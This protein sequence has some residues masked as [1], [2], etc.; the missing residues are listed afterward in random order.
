MSEEPLRA[1][2]DQIANQL[3]LAVDGKFDFTVKI[4]VAD[5]SAEKLQMLINFVIDTARRALSEL[6]AQKEVA[7]A[8][9]HARSEFL[10]TMSHE[11]RT[12]INGVIGMTG[13]LLDTSL[14]PEQW[15][16]AQA[17]RT[18]GDV[19]LAVINDILDFS[20]IEAGRLTIEPIPFDLQVTV[21]DVAEVLAVGAEAKGINLLVRYAPD[22]P[23][24]L[25]GDPGRI[26]QVL[27][28]LVT[29]AIKFTEKGHVF[30]NVE[31]EEQSDKEARM[32]FSVQDTGTG[33]PEDKLQSVFDKFTQADSS[34]TRKF[35]GTGLGLAICKQLVALMGGTV[36]ATSA[37]GEGSTFWFILCLPRQAEAP[38]APLPT[39]DLKDVRVLIVEDNEINQRVLQEQLRRWGLRNQCYPS[40]E[41]ALTTLRQAH[42]AGDPYQIA[43]LDHQIP[44]MDGETLGRAIKGDPLLRET[45]LVMLTSLGRRG[46]AE[47]LTE[48]GFSAYLVKP[49]RSSQLLDA[50]AAVWGGRTQGKPIELVTRH[51]LAEAHAAR[52]VAPTTESKIQHV[53]VLVAEDNVVNQRVAMRMLEKHGCRVDVAANGKEAV[54]MLETLPYDLIFMDCQMPEMDGFE[55]TREIRRRE[56]A[57]GRHIP[58]IAMTANA[59]QGDQE[60]C[61]EAGMDDYISKPV[62]PPIFQSVL[63]RWIRHARPEAQLRERAE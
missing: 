63:G 24:H 35:G 8:A 16:C 57:S 59:M 12:P 41:E 1:A 29:N 30:I 2:I 11:I 60:R 48:A 58:I 5:E 40:G 6:E 19:L 22:A 54:E 17:V 7:E 26:R 44:G 36:G 42:A 43:I 34:T 10:A 3:C 13:L 47:R 61:L 56:E 33:I 21:E 25:L 52:P 38:C 53:R 28:N 32:R 20:K 4:S 37:V 51:T 18:S 50:L 49:V 39:A 23:S 55:A 27:T 62:K 15:E 9:T 45:V 46:D 31:C 14:T